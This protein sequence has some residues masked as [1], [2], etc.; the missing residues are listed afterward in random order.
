[1][2]Y[3]IHVNVPDDLGS[4]VFHELV[5]DGDGRGYA[6]IHRSHVEAITQPGTHNMSREDLVGLFQ[7]VAERV[8][9]GDSLEGHI[10]YAMA[11]YEDFDAWDANGRVGPQP[12]PEHPFDVEARFRIGNARG[13]GGYR[14]IGLRL[15]V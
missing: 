6:Q 14:L 13:Q 5:G 4:H 9:D 12:V 2:R 8:S 10:T 3:T 1:M 15:V 7:E 11:G